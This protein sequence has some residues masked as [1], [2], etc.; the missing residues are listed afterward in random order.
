MKKSWSKFLIFLI[1][2]AALVT[3]G[4]FQARV[5]QI[6]AAGISVTASGQQFT[7]DPSELGFPKNGWDAA[8]RFA[9]NQPFYTDSGIK[10]TVSDLAKKVDRPAKDINV[11]IDGGIIGLDTQTH[12]G[13]V[14]N[15]DQ[16]AEALADS[17]NRFQPNVKLEMEAQ[18]PA[19]SIANA[20]KAL[21]GV[22][23]IMADSIILTHN[24][25]KNTV[26]PETIGTWIKTVPNGKDLDITFDQDKINTDLAAISQKY[27]QQPQ[28][29]DFQLCTDGHIQNFQTPK[30]G[31][32]VDQKVAKENILT[33]LESRLIGSDPSSDSNQ[34]E[35]ADVVV[36][37][38]VS[39]QAKQLGIK[40]LLGTATTTFAGSSKNR[41][42]NIKTGAAKLNGS[43]V[44]SGDEFS[45][46][47]LLGDVDAAHG[48]VQ[49]LVIKGPN[50]IPEFGGG[51]CQVSTTLFRSVLSAG[52]PVTERQNHSYR[53][54]F[55]EKDGDGKTIGPGL[56]AT[57]YDP[58]PDFRFKNDTAN[59]ILVTDQIVGN[60]IT[61]DIYG[62][63]DGRTAKV[64]G[65]TVL[66]YIKPA[67][68]PQVEVTQNLQPGA[69]KQVEF[70][71]TGAK[72]VADYQVTYADGTVKTQ[73][74]KSY[75]HPVQAK[76]QVGTNGAA[77]PAAQ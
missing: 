45:T 69:E 32:L 49:E 19:V 11:A 10:A 59:S 1:L 37:A 71:I 25:D 27:E 15:Q 21:A 23:S 60:K 75:Y 22:R 12:A 33:L 67:Q 5:M 73:E 4:F 47:K 70:A 66:E 7:I 24:G 30:D 31:V 38:N 64:I 53:V 35:L 43:L 16:A 58:H 62:T 9:K 20:E 41:I 56:D 57:I 18:T 55:Y 44:K 39:D 46:I 65:P 54:S 40:E 34:I 8:L 14:L 68:D 50:T 36:K 28:D 72:T 51:L 13:A 26:G 29:L 42:S 74:F 48:F 63:G 2:I 17:I 76:Y 52:L 3:L 77:A 61:F 6:R